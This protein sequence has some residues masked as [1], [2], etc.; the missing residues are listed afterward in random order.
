MHLVT[1]DLSLLKMGM[2]VKDAFKRQGKL[3]IAVTN[4]GVV[5]KPKDKV[6]LKILLNK[7]PIIT[8]EYCFWRQFLKRQFQLSENHSMKATDSSINSA[9]VFEGTFFVSENQVDAI[10]SS[11]GR[12]KASFFLSDHRNRDFNRMLD[13]FKSPSEKKRHE[14]T[15]ICQYKSIEVQDWLMERTLR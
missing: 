7:I 8:V 5:H 12:F 3:C 13:L 15:M 4:M 6:V 11:T 1:S 14:L 10:A 2:Y 9:C